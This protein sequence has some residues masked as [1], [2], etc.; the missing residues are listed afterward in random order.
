MEVFRLKL[1]YFLIRLEKGIFG[2]R[3]SSQ[4]YAKGEE[5]EFIGCTL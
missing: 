2:Y 3:Y 1:F 5:G 4:A